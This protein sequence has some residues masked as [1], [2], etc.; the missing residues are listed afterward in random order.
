MIVWVVFWCCKE[1]VLAP[2]TQRENFLMNIP[3]CQEVTPS[4]QML[5]RY[6]IKVERLNGLEVYCLLSKSW[7]SLISFQHRK[8]SKTLILFPMQELYSV[9]TARYIENQLAVGFFSTKISG[10]IVLA[11]CYAWSR[12]STTYFLSIFGSKNPAKAS[13]ITH[14]EYEFGTVVVK[15]IHQPSIK[16]WL[17]DFLPL[18]YYAVCRQT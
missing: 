10:V 5:M 8:S 15:H 14:F 1:V 16:E 4:L 18:I 9:L 6:F 3:I 2:E 17:N 11:I 13:Y 7:Y 12:N